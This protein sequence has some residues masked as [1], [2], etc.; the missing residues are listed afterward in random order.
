VTAEHPPLR[1][2]IIGCGGISERHGH[3]AAATTEAEIVACCDVRRTV[4]RD[5]SARHGCERAY[6]DY[7]TMLREHDLDGVIVATWPSLHR[8]HVLGCLAAGAPAVLCEKALALDAAEALDIWRA[9]TEAGALVIEA[10][11]YRHHP[12]IR[13]VDELVDD[14]RVGTL[15]SVTAAFSL[16]DPE[17]S[18]PDDPDRDWRQQVDRA[19]GV[20]FDLACYCVDACNRFAGSPPRRALALAGTSSRYGTTDQL[21]GLI[22]Y[23]NGV[24]GIVESS[25]R[26]H[27][28]HQLRLAGADGHLVLPVAWRI[29]TAIDVLLQRSVGWGEIETTVFPVAATNPFRLQLES[30]AAAIRGAGPPVP[31]LAESVT[32][33]ATLDALLASAGEGA[34]LPVEIPAAVRA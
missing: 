2:G 8:E 7:A 22:E 20:P 11:M 6:D 26:G 27:F 9:A 32:T 29:E 1:L 12:A 19:G 25:K 30:F 33:A 17:E 24:V 18:E 10:Y 3:A 23:E 16:L 28:D 4:A 14:G 34:A 13:R 21:F 31:S 15:D 5:W